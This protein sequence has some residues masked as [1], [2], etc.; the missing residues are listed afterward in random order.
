[1]ITLKVNNKITI[2]KIHVFGGCWENVQECNGSFDIDSEYPSEVYGD[3][4]YNETGICSVRGIAD[5]FKGIV[6]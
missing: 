1:M 2:I 3:I 4:I 5:H 6:K